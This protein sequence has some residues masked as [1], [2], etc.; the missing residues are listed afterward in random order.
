MSRLTLADLFSFGAVL[1]EMATGM[2]AFSG[3]SSAAIFHAILGLAPASP[4]SL[5]PR[6]PLEF[7]RIVSKALE[8][9]R[10]LRYQHAA[11]ILTDLKRLKRDTDSG[12]APVGVAPLTPSPYP[13]SGRGEPK[14]L[15]VFPSP[16]GRGWSPGA[17][18]GEGA[19]RWPLVLAATGL[20]LV[21]G[22]AIAWFLTRRAPV[23]APEL[24]ER[25]LTANPSENA[26]NQGAISPDGKYLAYSDQKG[27]HLQLVDSG[28]KH[29][30]PQPQGPGPAP[31]EWWPNAWFPDGTKFIASRV[32]MPFRVSTWIVSVLGGPPRKVRD[33]ADGWAVS[34]DGRLIA[35]GTKQGEL[36]MMGAN[37]EEPRKLAGLSQGRG[38]WQASWSPDGQRIAY[39]PPSSVSDPGCSIESRDLKGGKPS[40]ILSDP[41]LCVPHNSLCWALDGRLF[42]ALAEPAPNQNDSNL[43]EIRVDTRTGKPMGPP[44]R[45]THS[46][47]AILGEMSV[48]AD[49]KRMVVAKVEYQSDVYISELE[50]GGRRLKSRRRLTLDDRNDYPGAWTPDSKTVVFL[51]RPQRHLRHLPT[52][53]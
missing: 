14:S 42:F 4:L 41:R 50:V 1:Y 53:D 10:N 52:G 30:I 20:V 3:P 23:P 5:N 8:K 12:R 38:V 7:E 15:E 47:G 31:G 46:T 26:V 36:W 17:G 29:D 51:V 44:R 45:V 39:F 40:V 18:P 11:D 13:S 19:R 2:Q 21:A 49:G 28:E 6:L 25:R 32:E 24:K 22:A 43:W 9:D 33:D 37:G 34:P 48:T 16:S 35:F 27:M